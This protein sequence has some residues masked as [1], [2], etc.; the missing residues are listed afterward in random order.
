MNS[1]VTKIVKKISNK[2][3]SV[4][5]NYKMFRS[6]QNIV[7]FPYFKRVN[8]E[9]IIFNLED[10]NIKARVFIPKFSNDGL[11]IYIHGGGWVTGSIET[12][13][14]ICKELTN[15]TNR[16]V[17]SID[18]RLAP[19]YP[20]P[21]G[22]DDC[23]E[24]IKIIIDNLDKYGINKKNVCLMGDS[25]GGNLVAAISIKSSRTRDFKIN[26]QV[27]LYPALQSDYSNKTKYKSVIEKGKD[28]ILTQKNMQEYMSLYITDKKYLRS[29][30][31]SPLRAK[32]LFFQ[33]KTLIITAENDPLI[34]EGYAYFKKLKRYF[35]K[36]RYENIKGSIHGFLS[37]PL[38]MNYKKPTYEII[39]QFLEDD[40]E[41]KK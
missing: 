3:I 30:F 37:N 36:V 6:L 39:K 5:K 8:Y 21:C 26:K 10:R 18:Y 31:V 2:N 35:N 24:V 23:Y 27:L 14:T 17:I 12:H 40:Y 29:P 34:D 32:W 16:I 41:N 22:F 4:K 33:P 13:T 38:V 11:I 25:A 9:D 19:E 15:L 20:Y 1:V 7:N 28:Y